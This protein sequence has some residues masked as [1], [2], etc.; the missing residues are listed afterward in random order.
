MFLSIIAT[1]NKPAPVHLPFIGTAYSQM[2]RDSK[3]RSR[4]LRATFLHL[5]AATEN[6]PSLCGLKIV[7]PTAIAAG[8]GI[9]QPTSEAG[10][11][12]KSGAFYR[13]R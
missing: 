4:S 12:E 7:W 1:L 2:L 3:E 8:M 13:R 5:R 10:T 9:L 11:A 6:F